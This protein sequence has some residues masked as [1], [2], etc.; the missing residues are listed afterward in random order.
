MRTIEVDDTVYSHIQSLA[1]P[2]EDKSPNDTLKRVF[3]LKPGRE[4]TLEDLGLAGPSERKTSSRTKAPKAD[5]S[6]LIRSGELE[7]GEILSLVDYSGNRVSGA[8]A[9]VSGSQLSFERRLFSMS[10][11]A[12]MLLKK[13]GYKSDSVRGPSHWVNSDGVTIRELWASHLAKLS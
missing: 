10:E 2:Y 12:K 7:D 13:Q 3:G 8:T 6:Q 9:Q 1:I 4:L 11:L 5:L